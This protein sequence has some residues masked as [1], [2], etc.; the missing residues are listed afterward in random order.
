MEQLLPADFNQ[1]AQYAIRDKKKG[2]GSGGIVGVKK[3]IKKEKVCKDRQGISS[4]D[5]Q[6]TNEKWKI[7]SIYN[8]EGRKTLLDETEDIRGRRLEIIIIGGDFN[9]RIAEKGE[10]IWD[11]EEDRTRISKDKT[12][13][14]QGTELLEKVEKM[15][16]GF[17]NGNKEGDE[18]GEWTFTGT[19]GS[20]VI[21]Y[22]ICNAEAWEEIEKFKVGERT[23]SDHMPLEIV[24]QASAEVG[25]GQETE[26]EEELEIEGWSTKG[27]TLYKENLRKR[28]AEKVGIQDAWNELAEEVRKAISRR[29]IRI[30]KPKIREKKWWDKECRES[31]KRLNRMFSQI[32]IGKIERK[33][34]TEEKQRHNKLCENKQN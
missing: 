11:G 26:G 32:K 16:L 4:Y 14:R 22:A 13:N 21:D 20:S 24:L 2:R 31:K 10:I 15:G 8:R 34:Y 28:K 30:K 6:I 18:Q 19:L 12:E 29:K 25:K 27:A 17:L 33:I 1:E 5:L 3:I 9:A 7:I 23:E